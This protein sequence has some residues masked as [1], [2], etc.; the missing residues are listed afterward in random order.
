MATRIFPPELPRY[1][2]YNGDCSLRNS[3]R[4]LNDRGTRA[5]DLYGR[6]GR[7]GVE[8]NSPVGIFAY[9][10]YWNERMTLQRKSAGRA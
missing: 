7:S 2:P 10:D 4:L 9:N 1:S 5:V 3:S 8:G 6:T